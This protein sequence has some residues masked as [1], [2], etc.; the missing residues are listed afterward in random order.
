M[1]RFHVVA[2]AKRLVYREPD[3]IDPFGLVYRLV[4]MT[5]P[6]GTKQHIPAPARPEP[7]VLRCREGEW[8]EVTLE[9][10][11]PEWYPTIPEPFAPEVP[12]EI[13]N[14]FTHRAERRVSTQVSMHA[15]LVL[16]DV[17]FSD[18]AT[19]GNNSHQA[20]GKGNSIT[21]TWDT[22]RPPE[23]N[24]G[25]PLGAVLLQ[26]MADFRNHRHHGLIAALIIEDRN[27]TPY[28]VAA[29]AVTATGFAEAWHGVRATVVVPGSAGTTKPRRI[30]EAVLFLQ[31][32]LRLY[33]GGHLDYPVADEPPGH[34][35]HELD[36]E[37]Q[38]QKGF[39]Y[40]VEPVGSKVYPGFNSKSTAGTPPATLETGDWLSRPNPATPIFSVAVKSKVH[41][42]LVGAG[43]KPRQ[44]SFTVHGVAWPE[45]RFMS[46]NNRPL[47]SSES[48]I[49]TGTVR[50]FKFTPKYSGD[51]AYRSG[52]LKWA[53]PQG[54]WGIIRVKG[55]KSTSGGIKSILLLTLLLGGLAL[56][57]GRKNKK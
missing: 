2:E 41:L 39:N 11:L 14:Q 57:R 16:Y 4:S 19:V 8:V 3:L 30:E 21:Y 1:R 42:H 35:E 52:V 53:V 20:A 40:R 10:R 34:G 55:K 23:T 44:H 7:L 25:E 38:G 46:K 45:W 27:A 54:L 51:H 24:A 15:D 6:G 12:V 18:G 36:K 9:N 31:D 47:V 22:Y 29:G 48:A 32:G 37:D 5:P 26:D 17:K 43:D 13:R 50:K 28:K 33:F 49:T 56:G